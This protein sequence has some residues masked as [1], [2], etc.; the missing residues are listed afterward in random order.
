MDKYRDERG[1][2]LTQ[3]LF[4]ECGYGDAAI[5]TLKHR[6]HEYRGRTY[7]SIKQLYLE[8]EDVTEYEF[9]NTYFASW[10]HWVRICK[11]K[12]IT[13]HAEAWRRELEMKLRARGIKQ[14]VEQAGQGNIQAQRWLAERQW[15]KKIGR[16]TK[17]AIKREADFE[18][19]MH[20][21]FGADIIRLNK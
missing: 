3:S 16:P 8:M 2:L 15:D 1:N 13:P 11:N 6:D 21:E 20:D 14:M 4:L 7:P 19:V 9:A 5:Y 18:Q 12:L 10:D 17:E